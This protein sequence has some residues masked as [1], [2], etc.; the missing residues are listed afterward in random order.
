MFNSILVTILVFP[1][2]SLISSKLKLRPDPACIPEAKKNRSFDAVTEPS[3]N[4]LS[5]LSW[6]TDKKKD[7]DS[8]SEIILK[9]HLIE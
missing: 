3:C 1:L 5:D 7:Q 4:L 8:L 9:W 2:V 6:V